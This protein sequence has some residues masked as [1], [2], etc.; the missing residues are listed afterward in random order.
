MADT[1]K[2]KEAK[3]FQID[4]PVKAEPFFMKGLN[5]LDWGIQNR[6]S[7]IFN[8]DS[9]RTVMLAIDHGYF[10]GPTTGLERIDLNIVPIIPYC[11]ALMLTRGILRSTIPS[12][13][14][15]GVVVRATHPPGTLPIVIVIAPP[16]LVPCRNALVPSTRPLPRRS[17]WEPP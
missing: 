5:G 10:M 9:G 6:F 12:S 1:D 16:G 7:R 17:L 14:K 11:D 2:I 13:F 8:P 3:D 15:G 4:V